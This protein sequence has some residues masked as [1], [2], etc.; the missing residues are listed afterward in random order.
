MESN[1]SQ[2]IC[3]I[4]DKYYELS[5]STIKVNFLGRLENEERILSE[6]NSIN[7]DLAE[8]ENVRLEP[9][10]GC[11]LHVTKLPLKLGKYKRWTYVSDRVG[12][13]GELSDGLIQEKVNEKSKNI[14]K[15]SQRISD[16]RLLLVCNPG[17]NSGK[18][19]YTPSGLIDCGGFK[20]VY[21][22]SYPQ[23]VCRLNS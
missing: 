16:I 23:S 4:A 18:F 12:W 2:K 7:P 1:N 17:L 6:L 9:F 20:E 8:F 3:A 11:V 14:E 15:Y 5:E 21:F 13:V 10:R 19:T 22:L